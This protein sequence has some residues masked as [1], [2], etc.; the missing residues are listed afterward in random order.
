MILSPQGAPQSIRPWC[1][2]GALHEHLGSHRRTHQSDRRPGGRHRHSCRQHRFRQLGRFSRGAQPALAELAQSSGSRLAHGLVGRSNNTD[3]LSKEPPYQLG[4]DGGT[5]DLPIYQHFVQQAKGL[6]P[7]LLCMVIPSRWMAGGLGLSEF[8]QEMLSDT[9]ISHLVDY[10]NAA[11]VFSSVGI[12]GGACYFLRNVDHDG[13]CSVTTVKAGEVLG[14]TDRALGEFD[15]FVRDPRALGILHKVLSRAE[16]SL[17]D[18]LSARTAFG[19][20]SNFPGYREQPRPGDIKF[21]ATSPNGRFTAWVPPDAVT[22]NHGAIDRFKALIPKA[23]SGRERER[24]GVDMVLGPPWIADRPSVCTQSFLFV[25]TDTREE[26]ESVVSTLHSLP[27]FPRFAP[28][29][30]PRYE[31]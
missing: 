6:D 7:R 28:K 29:D 22:G 27:S 3:R 26:A 24:S 9:R 2:P 8:R 23:G 11:E 17:A 31:G 14:P 25:A 5:R 20:V 19:M 1:S 4:S 15:V 16:T 18:V 10:P 12:N 13:P 30:H 21:Y